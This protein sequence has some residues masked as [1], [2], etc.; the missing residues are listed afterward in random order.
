MKEEKH[1][2]L[3]SKKIA[4]EATPDELEQIQDLL[5][6]DPEWKAVLENLQE[7]W[8]SAPVDAEDRQNRNEDAYM[9]HINRLKLYVSDFNET[10]GITESENLSFSR[11]VKK[12]FYTGW[13]TYAALA[14][15]IVSIV[16]VYILNGAGNGNSEEKPGVNSVNEI[17]ISPGSKSKIQLPDGSQVWINS[18]SKLTYAGMMKGNTREVTLDGEAYFDV[19]KDPTHPFI[20]HTSGIDIK[21][22]GTAFNVKA[23]KEEKKSETSLIRGSIEVTVKNRP[24]KIMMKPNDKLIVNNDESKSPLEK[25]KELKIEKIVSA[26]PK[27]I[28]ELGRLTLYPV[29]NSVIETDWVQ[30]RLVFGDETLEDIFIKMERWYGVKIRITNEKLKKER[31]TGSFEKE[32]IAQALYALK[33]ATGLSYK[34]DKELIT[35]SK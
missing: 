22:L 19:V 3:L 34:I 31:Y 33:L 26:K 17:A 12:P 28:I 23:Y 4:G 24:G 32:T 30:N 18:G 20:V 25:N 16:A 6:T 27:P 8:V 5:N 21:V 10:D 7:F 9:K 35:I 29:D 15:F 1:W 14:S 11:P 2:I 13:F